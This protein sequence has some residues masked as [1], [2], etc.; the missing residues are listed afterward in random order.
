VSELRKYALPT[1]DDGLLRDFRCSKR[2]VA[3]MQ[4]HGTILLPPQFV[5][6]IQRTKYKGKRALLKCEDF[7][8]SNTFPNNIVYMSNGSV[9]YCVDF[10]VPN[11][12]EQLGEFRILGLRF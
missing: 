7:N 8:I 11:D 1:D 3:Y 9:V 5:H 12:P 10:Y 6:C 2:G 4:Q